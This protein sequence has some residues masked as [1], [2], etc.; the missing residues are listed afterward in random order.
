MAIRWYQ[1]NSQGRK[2]RTSEKYRLPKVAPIATIV[3]NSNVS[4]RNSRRKLLLAK[5][6]IPN[7]PNNPQAISRVKIISGAF[8][9]IW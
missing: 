4:E 6:R 9:S 1:Q 7:P 5:S 3:A 8:W 2:S